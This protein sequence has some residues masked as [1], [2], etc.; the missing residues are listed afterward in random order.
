M[1]QKET[2]KELP[3]ES[4]TA[5]GSDTAPKGRHCKRKSRRK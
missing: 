1:L 5:E 4:D 3:E 2:N